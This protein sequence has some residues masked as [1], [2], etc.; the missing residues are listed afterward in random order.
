MGRRRT[1]KPEMRAKN[2]KMAVARIRSLKTT[3]D[4]HWRKA[5]AHK[6][7]IG[8]GRRTAWRLVEIVLIFGLTSSLHFPDAFVERNV[9]ALSPYIVV[10][11]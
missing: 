5:K 9:L 2:V 4:R 8:Q 6:V 11:L 7:G 10:P 3:H 1:L